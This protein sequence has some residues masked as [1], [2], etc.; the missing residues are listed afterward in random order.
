MINLLI[1]LLSTSDKEVYSVSLFIY[2]LLP[3]ISPNKAYLMIYSLLKG[4]LI[5]NNHLIIHLLKGRFGNGI[6]N[7]EIWLFQRGH[8]CYPFCTVE[9]MKPTEPRWA[10][11]GKTT[12]KFCLFSLFDPLSIRR[13]HLHLIGAL[14]KYE[15]EKEQKGLRCWVPQ[16]V[17]RSTEVVQEGLLLVK[18]ERKESRTTKTTSEWALSSDHHVRLRS[19]WWE[20]RAHSTPPIFETISSYF[21]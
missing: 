2:I 11:C 6:H 8:F 13:D 20:L 15:G 12:L 19:S 14:P 9:G 21:R 3:K 16:R 7:R 5:Y 17:L 18:A 4:K 1:F 10:G